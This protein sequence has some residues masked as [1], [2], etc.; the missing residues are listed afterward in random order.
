MA[1]I[2][3]CA[4]KTR[5]L[6]GKKWFKSGWHFVFVYLSHFRKQSFANALC[7]SEKPLK[8]GELFLIEVGIKEAGWSGHLRI[9]LTQIDPVNVYDNLPQYALPDL[10]NLGSSW[11]FPISKSAPRQQTQNNVLGNLKSPFFR[12]AYG[13]V[14]RSLLQPTTG[15]KD[16]SEMLPT[17]KAGYNRFSL[18]SRFKRFAQYFLDTGSRIGVIYGI[19]F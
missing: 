4:T 2:S 10:A 13:N 5:Q 15:H 12:T 8:P 16:S 19:N 18:S 9:G 11:I 14:S 7:F 6:W 17:G 3:F 1:R